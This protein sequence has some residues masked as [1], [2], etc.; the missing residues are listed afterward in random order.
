MGKKIS[1]Q[2]KQFFLLIS[3]EDMHE[4]IKIIKS[5]R[6]SK[7]LIDGVTKTANMK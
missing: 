5:L 2:E 4:I 1:E 6:D 3:N 7:V